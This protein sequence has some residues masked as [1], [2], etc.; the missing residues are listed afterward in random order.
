MVVRLLLTGRPGEQRR[1]LRGPARQSLDDVRAHVADLLGCERGAE[2]RHVVA[3][4]G[5]RLHR[6]REIGDAD[7]RRAAGVAALPVVAMTHGAHLREEALAFDEVRLKPD[8]T[9]V[10]GGRIRPGPDTPFV[11]RHSGGWRRGRGRLP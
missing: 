6:S 10:R 7:E 3:A 11:C 9:F 8:T 4:R 1:L 5:H 2:W